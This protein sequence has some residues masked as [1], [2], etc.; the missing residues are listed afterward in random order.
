MER[1]EKKQWKDK[2]KKQWLAKEARGSHKTAPARGLAHQ[3]TSFILKAEP[4]R[5]KAPRGGNTSVFE[6]FLGSCHNLLFVLLVD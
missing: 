4:G 2:E 1:Y 6:D 5:S 3:L